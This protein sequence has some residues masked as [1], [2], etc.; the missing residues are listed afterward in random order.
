MAERMYERN[1]KSSHL[2][3]LYY[4]MDM[5]E[6]T[7]RKVSES[8]SGAESPDWNL[9]IEGFLLHYRNLIEFFSGKKHRPNGSDI[10]IANSEVWSGRKLTEAEMNQLQPAAQ[11]LEDEYW[12]DISQFLQHCTVRRHLEFREWDIAK[13]FER[14]TPVLKNFVAM[15]PRT[16]VAMIT[17][18]TRTSSSAASTG[19]VT[20][21]ESIFPSK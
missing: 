20:S 21:F 9:L 15:F 17:K 11:K 1:R 5:L 13:M 10:S 18:L 16:P 14:L 2:A 4:E 3:T 7:F 6:F 12:V 19:T 8:E